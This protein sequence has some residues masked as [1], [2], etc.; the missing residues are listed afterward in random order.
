MCKIINLCKVKSRGAEGPSE[1]CLR[2]WFSSLFF[3]LSPSSLSPSL[4]LYYYYLLSLFLFY[5]S[6]LASSLSFSYASPFLFSYLPNSPLSFSL[7][8]FSFIYVTSFFLFLCTTLPIFPIKKKLWDTRYELCRGVNRRDDDDDVA[9]T[10]KM[11]M[12]QSI[13]DFHQR[14]N[15]STHFAFL[16]IAKNSSLYSLIAFF[17]NCKIK[18]L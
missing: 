9:T 18:P 3:S 7:C 17:G 11:L 12:R 5:Y 10:P 16:L 15:P 13:R 1:D 8:R 4:P 6:V 14:K 2:H